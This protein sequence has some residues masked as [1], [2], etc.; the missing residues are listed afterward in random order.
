MNK[1][2]HQFAEY[3]QRFFLL[4]NTRYQIEVYDRSG[5]LISVSFDYTSEQSK[6]LTIRGSYD[7]G[8]LQSGVQMNVYYMTSLC[9]DVDID[10][11]ILRSGVRVDRKLLHLVRIVCSD[12]DIDLTMSHPRQTRVLMF[13][14]IVKSYI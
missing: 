12:V 7:Q 3:S 2:F 11:K 14:S 13:I 1:F 9:P 4:K 8:F 6:F 5:S 10:R